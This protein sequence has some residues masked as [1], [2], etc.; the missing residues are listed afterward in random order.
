MV[1][2]KIYDNTSSIKAVGVQDRCLPGSGSELNARPRLAA[3]HVATPD[4]LNTCRVAP[5][6]VDSIVMLLDQVQRNKF[7]DK[8]HRLHVAVAKRYSIK[9]NKHKRVTRT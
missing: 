2:F 6:S 1:K 3:A 4:W 9:T 5:A 7:S 8:R